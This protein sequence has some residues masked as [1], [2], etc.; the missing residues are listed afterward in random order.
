MSLS[1]SN[2]DNEGSYSSTND[3]SSGDNGAHQHLQLQ[4]PVPNLVPYNKF[5]PGNM[6]KAWD[7]LD[8]IAR[9]RLKWLKYPDKK[10]LKSKEIFN[11]LARRDVLTRHVPA[12]I[13]DPDLRNTYS[14]I[15]ICRISTRSTSV[16]YRITDATVDADLFSIEIESAIANH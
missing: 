3:S 16:R 4:S 14:I 5:W 1:L 2:D 15:G 8:H 9:I 11:K 10:S 6:E 12:T 7:Y 13:T